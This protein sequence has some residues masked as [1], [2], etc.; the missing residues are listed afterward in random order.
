[1]RKKRD[2]KWSSKRVILTVLAILLLLILLAVGGV[3][4]YLNHLLNQIPRV[5]PDLEYTLSSSAAEE[6][7]YTDPELVTLAPDITGTY[8]K[9]EDITFPSGDEEPTEATEPTEPSEPTQA[10]TEPT[11]PQATQPPTK[12]VETKPV[13]TKPV[14]TK[15][16]ETKPV[17]TKPAPTEPEETKANATQPEETKPKET[18]PD[19]ST[20]DTAIYSKDVVNILLVGQDRKEGESRKR[21]DTMIL[22]SFNPDAGTITLTSFMRDQYVQIPG[23]KPNKLNAAYVL[24]GMKLLSKTLKLNYGV[25]VDGVVVVDLSGFEKIIDL[26]GG[27]EVTLTQAEADY[28]NSKN[29]GVT[30]GVNRFTGRMALS[31][32]RVR[33]I[34]S[35][36]GRANRQRKLIAGVIESYKNLS[37]DEMLDLLEEILPYVSTNLSNI[38]IVGYALELFPM[39]A[40]AKIQTLRIP[41]DGTFTSGLV[42]V[43]DGFYGWFQYNIDFAANKKILRETIGYEG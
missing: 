25:D 20:I 19:S 29:Y 4:I 8:P 32:V 41:V 30:V 26:L 23:Y 31:Y 36:Y 1:M 7:L 39:L 5:D 40:T 22:V 9:L 10:P 33:S 12:P 34:D 35:D 37:L 17:E 18:L 16:E 14:E 43:R 2:R 38:D 24:G 11:K 27:V 28:F 3:A 13:E 21:S 15:P 42:E 6:Y